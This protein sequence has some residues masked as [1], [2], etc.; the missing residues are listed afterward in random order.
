M[1][2]QGSW[3]RWRARSRTRRA[4]L[5]SREGAAPLVIAR[6]RSPA[7]HCAGW[8]GGSIAADRP[9]EAISPPAAPAFLTAH[10]SRPR[11]G[12]LRRAFG[13]ARNDKGERDGHPV[14]TGDCFAAPSA[15]L[16][17]TREFCCHCA[18]AQPRL[19]LRGLVG[20]QHRSRPTAR[21]NLLLLRKRSRA[22]RRWFRCA[23][24]GAQ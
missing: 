19:S 22:R 5:S 7:C 18:G 9:P 20:R 3:G 14:L 16:A 10:S 8:S 6:G 4:L 17:M 1:A 24:R 13:A 21:S 15:W 23:P 2:D 11:G 12:L